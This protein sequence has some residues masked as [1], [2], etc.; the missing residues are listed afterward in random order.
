MNVQ[1]FSAKAA[2]QI[3]LTLA[4]SIFCCGSSVV[5][6]TAIVNIPLDP[7][8]QSVASQWVS[9]VLLAVSDPAGQ[10]VGPTG[11][12][13]AYGLLGTAMYDAWSAYETT[14]ASTVLGDTLQQ[15][16]ASNTTAN[17]SEAISYAAF[18]VLSDLFPATTLSNSFRDRM[19]T[20]GYDPDNAGSSAANIGV[21]MAEALID[22]RA[23]DGSNQVGGF[24]NTTNYA[25][26]NSASNVVN[27]DRW[28]PENVPIGD[29]SGA[30]QTPLHPQWGGVT[31]FSLDSNSQFRPRA[32]QS[33]LL[34]SNA[35][36][37]LTAKT[38]TRANGDVV[39]ISKSLIGVDINPAFI[40]QAEEVV[41]YSAKLSEVGGD[42]KKM[43]AEFWEDP[44]GSPYPPGTW[45][46]FGQKI[47]ESTTPDLDRDV[48][49]F[50][51]AG[52]A[53]MDAGIAT[54]EAKYEY[55]YARP[56]RVVREL[57]KLGLIGVENADGEFE[58]D[59]WA[60]VGEGTET[61][62]AT[63]FTTFQ[64]PGDNPSPPFP[65]FTSGH[66]AFS[67]AA[68]RLFGLMT[69][70][71]DFVLGDGATGL[72]VTFAPGDS[73]FEPG[74]SPAEEVTLSWSTFSEAADE[75]GLSR[76]FGGIHFNEGDILGRELG[77]AVGQSVFDRMQFFL[78]GGAATVPESSALAMIALATMFVT[79]Q[80]R[81]YL[82]LFHFQ[83]KPNSPNATS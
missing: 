32:P 40:S 53:V 71:D 79:A 36:A 46:F 77:D 49:L 78:G 80:R 58:I 2:G 57:G 81:R 54:W 70:S 8:K 21:T 65:E 31:S 51:G 73:R 50:F 74:I 60:G 5:A 37:N 1:E 61:I 19:S 52:N 12:S 59:A 66:S 16:A 83:S 45:M 29:V 62:L 56:V 34:D 30:T 7:A 48:P 63:E 4:L 24:A 76:L 17:K 9:E 35:T 69:G 20:L 13:R 82:S 64:T 44:S 68:A 42:R 18:T 26:V 47:A 41:A 3:F 14:P 75:A 23:N 38:I 39:T 11:A 6:Q 28:T 22:R 72:S 15:P 55:D 25:P 10:N 33:F 43:I 67:A 27:M